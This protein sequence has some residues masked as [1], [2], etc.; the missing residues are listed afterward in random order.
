[1]ADEPALSQRQATR[2][3]SVKD[4][5]RHNALKDGMTARSALLPGDD[6][7][8]LA[9]RRQEM[10]VDMQPRNSLEATLLVQFANDALITN[11][12]QEAALTQAS[13]RIRHEPLD[14]TCAEKDQTLELGEHLLFK[15]PR[16]LPGAP[17]GN[18]WELTEPPAAAVAVHPRHPARALFVSSGPFPAA[19]GCSSAGATWCGVSRLIRCG[20]AVRWPSVHRRLGD[21]HSSRLQSFLNPRRLRER[22]GESVVE[23][24]PKRENLAMNA[25]SK[26]AWSIVLLGM[27]VG[28]GET[29]NEPAPAGPAANVNT[30]S[31]ADKTPAPTA[32]PSASTAGTGAGSTAGSGSAPDAKPGEMKK[33]DEPPAVEGPKTENSKSDKGAVKLT[34]D[35][36]TAIKE[37]PAAEQAVAIQQAV[38]PVSDHHLGSM[39]KPLKVTAEGRTFYLCCESCE[40]ELKADPKAVIAKLDKK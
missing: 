22:R 14:Q 15:P 34:D 17:I 23:Q 21:V 30:T 20:E 39:D 12:C 4:R 3:N 9:A 10:L 27:A 33:V 6:A 37:L 32:P 2:A 38:C 24:H 25:I 35:E 7:G 16:P 31:P 36:L 5:S 40:K 8:E 11:R 26:S 13:F 19:T 28:C 18:T 29:E 1:M